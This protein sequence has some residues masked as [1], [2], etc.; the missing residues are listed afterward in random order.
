MSEALVIAILSA[1]GRVGIAA[2]IAFLENRGSTIDDA[3]AALKLA[4]DKSLQDY[5]DQDAA[6]RLKTF[7]KPP[8]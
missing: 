7:T 5:I 2:V 4:K 6:E 3:I 8:A 1:I